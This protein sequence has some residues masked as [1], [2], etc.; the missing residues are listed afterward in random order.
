MLTPSD[1]AE[2]LSILED[3]MQGDRSMALSES[4]GKSDKCDDPRY[5]RAERMVEKIKEEGKDGEA[6]RK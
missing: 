1:H 5:K 3:Y 4:A 2:I 6:L